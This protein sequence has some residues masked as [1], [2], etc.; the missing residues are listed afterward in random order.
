[1]KDVHQMNTRVVLF[2]ERV[3]FLREFLRGCLN[4]GRTNS[5]VF[6]CSVDL[7]A[8]HASSEGL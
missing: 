3:F 5:D 1:V 6:N 8:T 4:T 2:F 7:V